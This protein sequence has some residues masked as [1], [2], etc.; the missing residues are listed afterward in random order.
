METG[1]RFLAG[2]RLAKRGI[3]SLPPGLVER[4]PRRVREPGGERGARRE[5]PLQGERG[6]GTAAGRY[7]HE[8]PR[9]LTR[10]LAELEIWINVFPERSTRRGV[11]EV[12]ARDSGTKHAAAPCL[13]GLHERANGTVLDGEGIQAWLE[14]EATH[15][16]VPAD[17]S[18]AEPEGLVERSAGLLKMPRY[19][20]LHGSDW[21]PLP[22]RGTAKPRRSGS[23]T[24]LF[25]HRGASLSG[26]PRCCVAL[27]AFQGVVKPRERS[28]GFGVQNPVCGLRRISLPRTRVNRT[29]GRAGAAQPRP[30]PLEGSMAPHLGVAVP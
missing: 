25:M 11:P 28:W 17:I 2:D 22:L 30:F 4:S 26:P 1:I 27:Y 15:C 23:S 24:V 14:W 5:G 12:D 20:T 10:V 6:P 19:S 21:A 3:S 16:R 13:L 9:R 29:T 8:N 18:R 7:W